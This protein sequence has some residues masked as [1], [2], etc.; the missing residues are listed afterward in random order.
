MS[1]PTLLVVG[2]VVFALMLLAIVF[3]PLAR[4]SLPVV[5]APNAP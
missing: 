4:F 2:I 1:D 3:T 5:L